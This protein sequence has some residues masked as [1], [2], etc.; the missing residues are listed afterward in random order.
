MT[1]SEIERVTDLVRRYCSLNNG[2]EEI[3]PGRFTFRQGKTERKA[4]KARAPI[5]F[6][7][8]DRVAPEVIRRVRQLATSGGGHVFLSA[9]LEN[10]TTPEDTEKII[11][12]TEELEADDETP[13]GGAIG[14]LVHG[15]VRSNAQLITENREWRDRAFR[16]LDQALEDRQQMTA[17]AIN[18]A[19][20]ERQGTSQ[21]MQEAL[22]ALAPSIEAIAPQVV[23]M[24]GRYMGVPGADLPT[25]PGPRADELIR[26]IMSTC[27]EAGTVLQANPEIQTPERVGSLVELLHQLAALLG[28][29]VSPVTPPTPED[30]P[31]P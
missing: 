21:D 15:L 10:E 6:G 22:K 12:V 3:R 29:T 19:L 31:N 2:D 23:D 28:F 5:P 18:T 20:L 1:E 25:E 16:G 7:D 8:F 17:L 14:A 30:A 27:R 26:R 11:G 9:H 13:D 4:T 24:I